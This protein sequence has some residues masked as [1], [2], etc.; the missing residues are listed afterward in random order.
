MIFFM[1]C[2]N[3]VDFISFLVFFNVAMEDTYDF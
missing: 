1:T 2:L 3:H